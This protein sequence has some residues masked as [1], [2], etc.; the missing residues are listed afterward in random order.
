MVTPAPCPHINDA[1]TV[2]KSVFVLRSSAVH[3]SKV[4]SLHIPGKADTE[5]SNKEN[6]K[7]ENNPDR[8]SEGRQRDCDSRRREELG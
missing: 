6:M 2:I 7:T 4:T 1:D 5:V 8:A 3:C